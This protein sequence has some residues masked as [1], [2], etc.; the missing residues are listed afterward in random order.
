MSQTQT[1]EINA[2]KQDSDVR[3]IDLGD[4]FSFY[5][6]KIVLIIIAFA[7]GAIAAAAIT[8]FA[9]TPKYTATSTM[10]MVSS[11]TGSVVD[12][13]DLNLGTSLSSDYIELIKTR[14]IVESV[15]ED[16]DLD[17]D[18]KQVLGM[19]NIS[20]VSG[21]RII[22]I[23]ITSE[24]PEEAMLMANRFAEKTEIQIPL[25]MD[26]PKPNIAE[27]AILPTSKSSPSLTRNVLIGALICLVL[28]LIILTVMYM[29]DDTLKSAEDVEK[30]FGVM[31][32]T[33]IP[34]G[35]IEGLEN[36]D[37]RQG[38]GRKLR[39]GKKRSSKSGRK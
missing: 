5:I 16:L 1:Q 36:T 32:L 4:L 17:Y 28:M 37:S 24:D 18:Y 31:P 9:I 30:Y 19:M 34:E 2:K 10:Y 23:A 8:K 7:I 3:E 14:P 25:L 33:T 6:S 22:K 29:M 21:T 27:R 20:V 38:R 13:T 12:L 15:I 11:S 26:T 39:V 35:K